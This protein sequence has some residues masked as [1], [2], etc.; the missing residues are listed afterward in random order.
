MAGDADTVR[1]FLALWP[2]AASRCA[3][4]AAGEGWRWPAG[5]ARVPV[6]RLHLTLHFIGGLPRP[7]LAE[8]ADALAL[9]FEP[10]TLEFGRAELWHH[11]IA[12]LCP[13]AV[14]ERLRDLH[15][16]LG[17]ALRGAGIATETRP[18]RPHV[19][20]AKRAQGATPPP[21]EPHWRW[22]LRG[23]ALVISEQRPALTYR[24]L[25]RYG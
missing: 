1:L 5:A 6:E 24:V 20:L 16:G 10:F 22:P 17:A 4:A 13:L 12:A 23:Y 7:R 11:G 9:P 25:R 2:G 21:E 19:T 18:F 15:V 3:L 14:P 8:V